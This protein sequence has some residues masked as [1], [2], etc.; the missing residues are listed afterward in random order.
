MNEH[1]ILLKIFYLKHDDSG[2]QALENYVLQTTNTYKCIVK[3]RRV[4]ILIMLINACA[5]K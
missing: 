3:T 2:Q 5:D 4:I 1:K